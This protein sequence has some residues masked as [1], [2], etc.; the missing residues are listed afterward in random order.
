VTEQLQE[1]KLHANIKMFRCGR[2]TS[3][4]CRRAE[5]FAAWGPPLRSGPKQPGPACPPRRLAISPEPAWRL[6]PQTGPITPDS[7]RPISFESFWPWGGIGSRIGA[8]VEEEK[9]HTDIQRTG[10][11]GQQWRSGPDGNRALRACRAVSFQGVVRTR[12]ASQA[13]LTLRGY[14]N[15]SKSNLGSRPFDPPCCS[16]SRLFCAKDGSSSWRTR[17]YQVLGPC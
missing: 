5:A 7:D 8:V 17:G 2:P 11:G 9:A 4:S 16:C 14:R 13:D 12:G 10:V 6:R 1:A 15:E 3:N